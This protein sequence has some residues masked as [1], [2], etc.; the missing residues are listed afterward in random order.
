M[1]KD[2]STLKLPSGWKM[3]EAD[4][5]VIRGAR[6][7][8]PS[9]NLDKRTDL[10]IKNGRIDHIGSV[11]AEFNGNVIEASEWVVCPGLFDMHVHL[12]EPGYEYKET[13]QTGCIA[14]MAGGFTGVAPMPNT[15]PAMDNPGVVNLV[16][17]KARG[18]PVDVHPIA[19][20]T[21]GRQGNVL[22]EI[23]ELCK[24][25]V[26]GFSDDGSPVTS[27]ELMRLALEYT[28][29]FNVVVIEHCEEPT[30]TEDGV[31]DEG[32]VSTELGLP[33]CPSVAEDT[34]VD[35]NIRI[36][37]YIGGRLHIAHVSTAESV[38]LIRAAKDRGVNVTAEVTPHHLTLDS[39]VVRSF[40]ANY[41]VNPPLRTP[42]DIDALITGLAEG[43]ID[44][45]ATD[46]APHA[47]FEK[48]VEFINAPFGMIGLETALGVILTKLVA[49]GKVS[50][51]RVINAFTVQPRRIL[52]LPQAEIKIG[53][54]ANLTLFDPNEKWTVDR[55]RMLSKSNN[56]PYHGLELT[57]RTRGI[58]NDGIV[59]LREE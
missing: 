6:L 13:V 44:A 59:C 36:A 56:T 39:T 43:V 52:G 1:N 23:S 41:K 20:V 4:I 35:R 45:I 11:E 54:L 2:Y 7:L 12:R 17:G 14:A 25:G 19:A 26:T 22:A 21:S 30:L 34:A 33:G 53:E 8:D 50:L 51:E 46:H 37:E 40:D 3:I 9:N 49:N 24:A 15:N 38:E 10:V 55:A 42:A 48:E 58:I 5:V 18:I 57:G 32:A 29:M 16:R 31:M 27:A 28:K 47:Q